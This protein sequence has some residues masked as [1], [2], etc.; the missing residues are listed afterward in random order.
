MVSTCKGITKMLADEMM[1]LYVPE[2]KQPKLQRYGA[3][4]SCVLQNLG[5]NHLVYRPTLVN[6][7]DGKSTFD[8]G[9]LQRNTIYFKDYLDK[10]GITMEEAYENE[11]R[12]KLIELLEADRK[13]WYGE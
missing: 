7:I 13:K 6:H 5:I 12:I 10:L 11:N 1:K 2:E 3:L 9:K 8:N 4:L